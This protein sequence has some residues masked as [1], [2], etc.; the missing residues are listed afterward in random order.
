[1]PP[2]SK[3]ACS[4]LSWPGL[5]LLLCGWLVFNGWALSAFGW[6]NHWGYS[7]SALATLV[8]LLLRHKHLFAGS[9]N[10]L[11]LPRR[12][13]FRRLPSLLYAIV[14]CMAL[15][16]GILYAPSNYDALGYRLPRMLQ[17]IAEGG[18]HWI[19]TSHAAVNTR[20][21][22]SEWISLPLLLFS[23]S[24]RLLF[25]PNII[26]FALLPG[27]VFGILTRLGL[28]RRVAWP[29]MWIFPSGYCFAFQA[30][31]IGNDLIGAV[32]FLS[33]IFYALKAR[34]NRSWQHFALACIGMALATG[35][36]TSN[37]PLGLPW[38]IAIL[39][40][41]PLVWR[42][43][44]RSLALAPVLITLSFI[45]NAWLNHKHCGDWTG[46]KVEPVF[47]RG[48]DPLLYVSWNI[49]YL[50]IQNL[51]PP[52]LPINQ[53]WNQAVRKRIPPELNERLENNFEPDASKW[54]MSET[55][56]EENGPLGLGVVSLLFI[57]A[58]GGAAM[59]RKQPE[60]GST[61]RENRLL[62]LVFSAAMISLLPML[63]KSGLTGSGRYLAPHY[64]LLILP[65][66]AAPGIASFMRGK[67]W[68]AAI[69]LSFA[70]L[71]LTMV[72]SAAR[73]L[74]PALTLLKAVNAEESPNRLLKRAWDVYTGYRQ[75]PEAFASLR[76]LL[77]PDATR[78]GFLSGN[79]PEASL[80][81]PFGKRRI[82][83]IRPD[84]SLESIHARGIQYVVAG[85][86]TMYEN[87]FPSLDEWCLKNN[88]TIIA[89][90]NLTL[91]VRY[92]K[93][94][95]YVIKLSP[96]VGAR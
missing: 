65:F 7:L 4:Q 90:T 46:L 93:E 59:R 44:F 74:W 84:D 85:K 53:I 52:I 54:A 11:R 57:G 39:P 3:P 6:L 79:T 63:L 51:T 18:W 13:R 9:K 1:M 8:F 94:P 70:A 32:L 81:K 60:A 73:P 50:V 41:I 96:Q 29:W 36:K 91:M 42:F 62:W 61:K 30:G 21:S 72:I 47:M 23:S 48:G 5:W 71:M 88:G 26:S 58:I 92:D 78:I 28:S 76:T 83:H 35:S 68:K 25:L 38:L 49:P 80:W 86:R 34:K 16:G 2:S 45:P 27:L 87:R 67:L 15:L 82:I 24:D 55:M 69:I 10:L 37:V 14:F 12:R 40:A 20:S 64:L 75:R 95:W 33:G 56:M 43:P 22:V 19:H 31:S 17:W 77:P 89:E 66:L